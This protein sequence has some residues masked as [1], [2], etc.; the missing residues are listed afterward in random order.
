MI[1][2]STRLAAVIG[3]PVRHS[4]SPAIHNAAFLATGLDWVYVAL[5]VEA[6]RVP[7]AI[8]GM[9]ALGIGGLS[10]T[11]PHKEAVHDA[12][13]VLDAAAAALRTVNTVVPLPDG[14]L[15]GHTTDGAGFVDSLRL[16]A[17]VDPAGMRVAV[18]GAGGAARAVVDALARAGAAEVVVVNRSADRGVA[19]AAL[20]GAAGRAGTL[21]DVATADLVVN[22]TS[23]GMGTEELPLDPA[24]LH[25]GQV[26][27][28]LV[29]HPL[30]TALL[31]AARAAGARP[32]DGL[33]MLV[34]Q[35]ARAFRLWTGVDAPVA[36]MRDAAVAEIAARRSPN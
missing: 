29:Y 23:I 8:A 34:H 25:G 24:L 10:V 28:D 17:G 26:V 11:M 20:A 36:V 6:G 19:A 35:A 13:D 7:E 14:R 32:V 4:L 27:A 15:A 30:D 16:D 18:L 33:G 22:A 9:R 31:R 21:A 5:A 2:G 1:S 12:V 3:A